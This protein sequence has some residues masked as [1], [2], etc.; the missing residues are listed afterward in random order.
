[1]TGIA[2]LDEVVL[3]ALGFLASVKFPSHQ[4]EPSRR[5]LV[6]GSGNALATGRILF[7]KES[8]LF[9]SES[10]YAALLEGEARFD[11]MTV[12]S[13][14]GEKHSP[15]IVRDLLDRGFQPHLLT[16][17]RNSAAADLLPP[18]RVF[19][20][21]SRPE[22]PTYNVSTYLGMILGVTGEDPAAIARHLR[23]EVA[24]RIV[25]FTA[26]RAFYLVLP[27]KYERH[28]EM[29]LTKFD[30]LFGGRLNGRCYT[31]EQTLHAKTV[32]PWRRELFVS[33]G[34]RNDL[35]GKHRLDIHLPEGAGPAAMMAIGYFVIGRIQSQF[36][37][38]F[39]RRID[40]YRELQRWMFERI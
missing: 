34:W 18:E 19:V 6:I 25:D 31:V 27:S 4:L 17:N 20:T 28:R 8:A 36:P 12:I 3:Q 7:R 26:Y 30:E 33:L 11:S 2:D 29:F 35:F 9:A 38:W 39:K 40:D 1:M 23:D 10:R 37:P 24:G 21:P 22:P 32:V 5:R 15:I 16:C 14:S 13:A